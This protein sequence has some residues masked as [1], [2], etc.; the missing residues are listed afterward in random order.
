MQR[1]SDNFINS[2]GRPV[3]GA[4]V[5]VLTYPQG[6]PA[7]LYSDNGVTQM[8]NPT[9]TD[10]LGAF[11][12]YAAD[13][14]YSLTI[15]SD[16]T[17][18]VTRTDVQLEDPRDF[19]GP[20]N[21]KYIG[22]IGDGSTDDT[23]AIQAAINAL[24]PGG[25]LH[26]PPGVYL[27]QG[28]K[29]SG[30]NDD[31][32][33]LRYS[34]ERATIQLANGATN[35]NVA[36]ITSGADY[37]IDGDLTFRGNKGSVTKPGTDLGYRYFNGLYI[38]AN[39]GKTLLN[40]RV[41][42]A[43]FENCPY[44]GI[45]LGSGPV[46]PANIGPGVD[47]VT[48]TGCTLRG[49]E[50]GL[51]GGAY[52]HTTITGNV[53]IDNDIYGLVADDGC[54]DVAMGDNTIKMLSA[55]GNINAGIFL[56]SC[57]HVSLNGNACSGGKQG[58]LVST[59]CSN[60]TVNGN[61]V[62]A[63]TAHGITVSNSAKVTLGVNT[64]HGA[65]QYGYNIENGSSQVALTANTATGCGF[66]GFRLNAVSSV[67]L[68]GNQ[69]SSNNGSGI[70]AAGCT[71]VDVVGNRCLNNAA[72]GDVAASGIRFV[73][74][75]YMTVIGNRAFDSAGVGM[76]KQNYGVTE[77]GSSNANT[78]IGNDFTS[79]KTADTNIIGSLS[80]QIGNSANN[81]DIR[82]PAGSSYLE[83]GSAAA[84]A[85]G[86][87]AEAA[88]G[89]YRTGG[90][91]VGISV[92]GALQALVQGQAGAVNYPV[93]RGSSTTNVAFFPEGAGADLTMTVQ[94]KGAN[95]GVCIGVGSGRVAFY[96][97][98]PAVK[99]SIAGSRAG[100]AALADLLTKLAALGLITDG[101]TA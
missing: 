4:T 18:P 81:P 80:S 58:I 68:T 42:G 61:A 20:V 17:E 82:L 101:T 27:V 16:S 25:A 31:R 92:G 14:R 90:G 21:A 94:G 65:G 77:E 76:R 45:M 91:N 93:L 67:A 38:G 43:S 50:F 70:L 63:P 33:G 22:A 46:Q 48:I 3:S 36:E 85:Y 41:E 11:F 44:G 6:A 62:N 15:T 29:L 66:D 35:A 13:G 55:L 9:T 79:N 30:S 88:T 1:Y 47:H 89:L 74:S 78:Y 73:N 39:A 49:N 75:T 19:P 97:G 5:T 10:A 83:N 52:R 24:P 72:G 98:T 96:G 34:G 60:I 37:A 99:P 59:G 12:F 64:V 71:W 87:A 69:S 53:L 54:I 23:A 56:Y 28:L 84:P 2:N 95:G 32:T 51:A 86:F 7:T 40:V 100:N 57:D 26:F 8:A